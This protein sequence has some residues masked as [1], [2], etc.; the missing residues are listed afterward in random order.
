MTPN[1][2]YRIRRGAQA[3]SIFTLASIARLTGTTMEALM[4]GFSPPTL[5]VLIEWRAKNAV[6]DERYAQLEKLP[7][8]GRTPTL[9]YYDVANAALDNGMTIEQAARTAASVLARA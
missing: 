8:E 1:T 3:P 7:L 6:S 4:E 2:V 5:T 9:P